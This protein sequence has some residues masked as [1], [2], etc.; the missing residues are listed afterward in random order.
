MQIGKKMSIN[1]NE[2][3]QKYPK[4]YEHYEYWIVEE[5]TCNNEFESC[6]CDIEEFFD[7][8]ED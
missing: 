8:V 7:E 5:S 6:F 1:W 3:K 2:I 4:A